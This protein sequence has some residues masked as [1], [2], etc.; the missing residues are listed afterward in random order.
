MTVSDKD[1][2]LNTFK[3]FTNIPNLE[4]KINQTRKENPKDIIDKILKL[5]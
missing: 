5:L 1:F 3:E 4:E 2:V